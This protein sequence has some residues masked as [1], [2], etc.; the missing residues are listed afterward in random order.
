M[1]NINVPSVDCH[2]A[3]SNVAKNIE[4]IALLFIVTWIPK[5]KQNHRILARMPGYHQIT[6]TVLIQTKFQS[7][8]LQNN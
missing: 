5:I 4:Q 7:I 8:Y 2:T 6:K 3:A 1:E